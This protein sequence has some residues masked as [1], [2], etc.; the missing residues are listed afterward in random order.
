YR[1]VI[2]PLEIV[3]FKLYENTY[4]WLVD[5][6]NGTTV[7]GETTLTSSTCIIVT[8]STIADVA[9]YSAM[10]LNMTSEINVTVSATNN[11][12]LTISIDLDNI[13]TTI[14][15]QLIQVL[16]NITNTNSTI[17]DQT[18]DLLAYLQNVNSTLYAQTAAFIVNVYNN[19]TTIYEQTISLLSNLQNMNSTI[20]AQTLSILSNIS[21]I[22]ST[23][24]NQIVTV[25]SNIQ[26][27]NATM[28]LV[29]NPTRLNP[30]IL[31]SDLS[32]DYCDFTIVTNWH[33]ATLSIYDNEVLQSGPISEL[34]SPIRYPLSDVVGT[35]NLS[36]L[37]DA[38]ADIFWYNIS[39]TVIET[40]FRI[41]SG[42]YTDTESRN[43]FS[44]YA[45]LAFNYSVYDNNSLVKSGSKTAGS[46]SIDWEKSTLRGVHEWS[47]LF[48]SSGTVEW[49]NG[50]YEANGLLILQLFPGQD[51]E[52]IYLTGRLYSTDWTLSYWVWENTGSGNVLRG[53]GSITL[54]E[55]FEWFTL[56]WDKSSENV[57]ANWTLTITD[58]SNNSTAYGYYTKIDS[59]VTKITNNASYLQDNSSHQTEVIQGDVYDGPSPEAAMWQSFGYIGIVF[60]AVFLVG[61]T[62][63]FARWRAT[64][65]RKRD[66]GNDWLTQRR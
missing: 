43:Y 22:N 7:D 26:E 21:N 5:Y 11:Y 1:E 54:A 3:D 34:L 15:E 41:D 35:H 36:V 53:S 57:E 31:G 28:Y 37:V 13:N 17:F 62:Y 27:L 59:S 47:I 52:T 12:V 2:A 39:Y 51:N 65:R 4:T 14:N 45:N 29:D 30:L 49:V 61:F 6:R 8:G 42:P 56:Y 25:I 58:E 9:G 20:Y 32:D 63:Y 55:N 46:F 40:A 10:L 48:N 60:G 24:Y 23:I 64:R 50:S 16:L 38:E 19:Q 18:V 33:N 44:G 66:R